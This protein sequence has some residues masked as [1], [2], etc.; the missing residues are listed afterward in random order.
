MYPPGLSGQETGTCS[1]VNQFHSEAGQKQQ[2][3]T[4]VV[5]GAEQNFT[6]SPVDMSMEIWMRIYQLGDQNLVL[7]P[8]PWP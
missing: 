6:R 2:R 5:K 4:L 3:H 8:W 1:G 7:C